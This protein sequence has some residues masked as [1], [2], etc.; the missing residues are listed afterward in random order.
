MTEGVVVADAQSLVLG[1][2]LAEVGR[3]AAWADGF[4]RR[5]NLSDSVTFSLQLCLEEAVSNVIRHGVAPAERPE[6][7][8]RLDEGEDQ[9]IAEIEDEGQPF[10]PRQVPAGRRTLSVEEAETGGFG[11]PL[12]HRFAAAMSYERSGTRNRLVLKFDRR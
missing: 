7:L 10:D 11:I 8:V 4:A 1:R 2:D 6:I 12:M 3:M 5:A 9:I